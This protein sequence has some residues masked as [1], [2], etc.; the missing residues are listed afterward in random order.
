MTSKTVNIA[1]DTVVVSKDPGKPEWM[2]RLDE[3]AISFLKQPTVKGFSRLEAYL[4]LL[5]SCSPTPSSFKPAYE[6]EIA[7]DPFQ[8]IIVLTELAD[9]W[10]WSRETVRKFI[11][12]L[13][14]LG[15]LVKVQLD[16][17]SQLTMI[18]ETENSTNNQSK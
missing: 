4:F 6:Q 14:D 18:V 10:S 3:K 9:R 2:V 8:I 12:K 16:R 5:K 7:L 1:N 13:A 15:L 17:C 11:D